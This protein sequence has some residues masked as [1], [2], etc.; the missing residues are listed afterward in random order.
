MP[1]KYPLGLRARIDNR[2]ER[3][4]IEMVG[5][6]REP[7]TP[8]EFCVSA[9]FIDELDFDEVIWGPK[10]IR[11]TGTWIPKKTRRPG[12]PPEALD[13]L[14]MVTCSPSEPGRQSGKV[15]A[16]RLLSVIS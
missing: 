7:M 4:S 15:P 9:E 14:A 13:L 6:P 3:I 8:V 16:R 10:E 5:I 12:E 1:N 11:V 2:H